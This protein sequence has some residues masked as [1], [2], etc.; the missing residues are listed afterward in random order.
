MPIGTLVYFFKI[1]AMISVPPPDA[2][3]LNKMAALSAGRKI[4]KISSNTGSVVSGALIGNNFSSA[5]NPTD[6]NTL[7]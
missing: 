3:I 7:T 6:V 5:D 4:A 1:I 2:P